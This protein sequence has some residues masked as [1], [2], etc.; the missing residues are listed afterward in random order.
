MLLVLNAGRSLGDTTAN[1]LAPLVVN[2]A[3]RRGAQI[4]LDDAT[5][6]VSAPLVA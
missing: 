1:L 4:I 2:I 6:P 3:T 5:L